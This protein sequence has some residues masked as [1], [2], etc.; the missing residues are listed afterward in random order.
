[1]DVP[2]KA[3]QAS[4][5]EQSFLHRYIYT[6]VG[7]QQLM[8][9]FQWVAEILQL[10]R[11]QFLKLPFY[12]PMML[13]LMHYAGTLVPLISAYDILA[14]KTSQTPDL[15]AMKESLT[16]I[17]LG[18]VTGRLAGIGLVVDRVIGNV[19]EHEIVQMESNS[20]KFSLQ[21]IP[22][23]IWKPTRS[24]STLIKPSF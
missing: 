11:S 24:A 22:E 23:Q 13:G 17:R 18:S 20:F 2:I 10:E 14:Q 12:H 6:Q 3:R 19:S 16:A 5:P 4:L 15:S 1:M 9:P 21:D 7:Q 8:F